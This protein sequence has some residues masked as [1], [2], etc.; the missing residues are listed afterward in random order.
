MTAACHS[1]PVTPAQLAQFQQA[2]AQDAEC[3]LTGDEN[4]GE[5]DVQTPIGAVSLAYVYAGGL[6]TITVQSKPMLV[7]AAHIFNELGLRIV[8]ATSPN[9]APQEGAQPCA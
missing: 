9:Q 6:L 8:Q 5:L 7:S 2:I 1:Y 4:A 3:K